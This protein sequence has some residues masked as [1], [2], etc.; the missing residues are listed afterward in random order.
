[1]SEV[2]ICRLRDLE[3][4]SGITRFPGVLLCLM[5]LFLGAALGPS[6]PSSGVPRLGFARCPGG[7][8]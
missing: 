3:N 8:I 4:D 6:S 2:Q 5:T 1:M 7:D